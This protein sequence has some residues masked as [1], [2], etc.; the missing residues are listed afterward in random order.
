WRPLPSR[1]SS[2]STSRSSRCW[3]SHLVSPCPRWA[4]RPG[5]ACA[6]P[7]PPGAAAA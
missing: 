7:R 2:R 3:T 6:A 1:C 4:P 5:A